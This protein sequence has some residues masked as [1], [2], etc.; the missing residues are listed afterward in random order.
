MVAQAEKVAG[1]SPDQ[2]SSVWRFL[3]ENRNAAASRLPHNLR[4]GTS[5]PW[6]TLIASIRGRLT[7]SKFQ[8]KARTLPSLRIPWAS[9]GLNTRVTTRHTQESFEQSSQSTSVARG[10]RI[11]NVAT[12]KLPSLIHSSPAWAFFI[13]SRKAGMSFSPQCGCQMSSRQITGTPLHW[14]SCRANVVLPVPAQPKMTIR[15]TIQSLPRRTRSP[16]KE[17]SLPW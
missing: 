5:G 14:P 6:R 1:A 7:R 12:A 8:M 15:S 10:N 9:P 3:K 16:T 11:S 17:K 2:R 13:N 4:T